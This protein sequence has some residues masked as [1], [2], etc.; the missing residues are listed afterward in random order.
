MVSNAA[1]AFVV[2]SSLPATAVTLSYLGAAQHRA[3]HPVKDFEVLPLLVPVVIGSM[4]AAS[5]WAT[6]RYDLDPLKAQLGYGAAAG[7][8]MSVV[9]HDLLGLPEKLF[10]IDNDAE[11]LGIHPVHWIAPV[12][13][14]GLFAL[15]LRPLNKAVL[16][17]G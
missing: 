15:I 4:N 3:D 12:L 7:L 17:V 2:G 6:E 9:G 5:V 1:K 14:A 11:F 13:Y 10:G 16:D 8:L